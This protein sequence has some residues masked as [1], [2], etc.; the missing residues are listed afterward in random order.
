MDT[1]LITPLKDLLC[2]SLFFLPYHFTSFSFLS[3][4]QAFQCI[5]NGCQGKKSNKGC[6]FCLNPRKEWTTMNASLVVERTMETIIHDAEAIFCPDNAD[7]TPQQLVPIKRAHGSVSHFPLLK[8]IPLSQYVHG[9]V[10][11]LITIVNAI[12]S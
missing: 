5:V 2:T 7:K 9:P 12:T 8:N 6:M 11:A 10:H 1:L 4:D 3:G